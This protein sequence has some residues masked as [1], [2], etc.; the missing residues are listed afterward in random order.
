MQ[1]ADFAGRDKGGR[2]SA[3]LRSGVGHVLTLRSRVVGPDESEPPLLLAEIRSLFSLLLATFCPVRLTSPANFLSS[4][5]V[6]NRE[7]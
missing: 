2:C 4:H 6:I 3:V 1:E 5:V 7:E